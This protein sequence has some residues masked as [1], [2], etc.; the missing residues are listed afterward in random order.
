[1]YFLAHL[2]MHKD[3]KM[4]KTKNTMKTVVTL[5]LCIVSLTGMQQLFALEGKNSSVKHLLSSDPSSQNMPFSEGVIAGDLLF[6]SG[7][8]GVD[9]KTG[10]MVSGGIKA[11]AKQTMDN[12]K[13]TL[14]HHGYS[15]SDIVKCT[16]MIADMKTW[17]AFNEVYVTYF[18]KPYPARSAFGANGLALNGNLEVECIAYVGK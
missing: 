8:I 17:S 5:L 14:T 3:F 12:I 13:A 6:L 4:R 11:E 18:S 10:K 16:V 9:P 15:M 1:M 2:D 7:Q